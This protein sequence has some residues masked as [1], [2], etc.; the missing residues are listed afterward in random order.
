MKTVP[1]LGTLL[2]CLTLAACGGGGDE[3]SSTTAAV[4]IT[5]ADAVAGALQIQAPNGTATNKQGA[6]PPPSDDPDAPVAS[7]LPNS[8]AAE[9]NGELRIPVNLATN[10]EISTLLVQV[11]GANSYTEI[12]LATVTAKADRAIE[13]TIQL[14]N[15]TSGE[16]SI[17]ISAVDQSGRVSNSVRTTVTV[18]TANE[19]LQAM[20]GVWL[21]DCNDSASGSFRVEFVFSGAAFERR[22]I[23]YE[24]ASCG[25]ITTASLAS[26]A[27]ELLN[28]INTDS[29]V[30]AATIDYFYA[31]SD[32]QHDIIR[33]ED[34]LFYSGVAS[35]TAPEERPSQLDFD[36][37]FRKQSESVSASGG[38]AGLQPGTYQSIVDGDA[39]PT[40][41]ILNADGSGTV[42][43]PGDPDD[44][45]RWSIDALGALL[46]DFVSGGEELYVLTEG[47]T[48]SG[49]V[50][51]DFS[52]QLSAN[53]TW[54]RATD[55]GGSG[56]AG[57][58]SLEPGTYAIRFDGDP[59]D[60]VLVLNDDGSGR[61]I[62]G[63]GE[64]D[65]LNWVLD[66]DG[67]L[68]LEY[69][70]DSFEAYELTSGTP[71]SGRVEV[72]SSSDNTVEQA[73]WR[74]RES[75]D[76]GGQVSEDFS[77]LTPGTYK[78]RFDGDPNDDVFVLNDGG[79]GTL[80]T[81]SGQTSSITWSVDDHGVLNVT[82]G[83]DTET[84]TLVSGTPASG[85]VD[86][87]FSDGELDSADWS[88]QE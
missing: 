4:D 35:A 7:G 61:L 78:V 64:T 16:F 58:A 59:N 24:D 12:A 53:A 71:D 1:I 55:D 29:G 56:N 66:G 51:I 23:A 42:R 38:F 9:P 8:L 85:R 82:M 52:N 83:G 22:D 37:P 14:P 77:T 74:A 75:I 13:I 54:N 19:I 25:T 11:T 45:I 18:V 3:N 84:Y 87:R 36:G 40:T 32:T 62:A 49:A 33:V 47:T 5:Q 73:S 43:Y 70:D 31:E 80:T 57:F 34:G 81:G 28:V 67:V 2:L 76:D 72:Y 46:I 10:D 50:R 30:S 39:S 21:N 17:D 20:Q 41:L 63:S 26:G 6:L 27:F 79:S 65:D 44:P 88:R 60:D 69:G 15:L 86:V 68:V 48:E